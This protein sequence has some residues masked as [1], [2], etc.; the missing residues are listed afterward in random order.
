MNA[1]VAERPKAG[2]STSGLGKNENAPW[3]NPRV[4]LEEERDAMGF[5]LMSDKLRVLMHCQAVPRTK[6]AGIELMGDQSSGTGQ[7]TTVHI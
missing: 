2:S 3:Y 1:S 4:T 6:G 7:M 5:E